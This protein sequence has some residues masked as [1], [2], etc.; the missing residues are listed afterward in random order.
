MKLSIIVFRFSSKGKLCYFIGYNKV[1]NR[2]VR[3]ICLIFAE[4]KVE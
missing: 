1:V 2:N 3:D 4:P